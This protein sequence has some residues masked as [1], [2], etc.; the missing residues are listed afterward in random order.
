MMPCADRCPSCRWV[1][2]QAWLT[3][4]ETVDD[5]KKSIADADREIAHHDR[6][7][8]RQRQLLAGGNQAVH[9]KLQADLDKHVALE[10]N[11]MR[12]IPKKEEGVERALQAR[13][14]ADADV[15]RAKDEVSHFL[16]QV[17]LQQNA[18]ANLNS[19]RTDP[20]AA[21]GVNVQM[22]LQEIDRSRWYG[23]KPVGPLGRYVKLNE[24]AYKDL[25]EANLGQLLCAFAVQDPKDKAQLQRILE[26][27]GK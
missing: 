25:I 12:D 14:D 8:L 4:K 3:V 11:L 2:K 26:D 5:Y 24:P 23:N 9:D 1:G 13:K 22:V 16:E 10:Q 27:C 6:A 18:L 15:E 20:L 19:Q 17:Q 7:L 21:F